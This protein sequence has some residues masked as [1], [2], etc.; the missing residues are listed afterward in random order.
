MRILEYGIRR[1][2]QAYVITVAY[3]KTF[4]PCAKMVELRI[5]IV[6]PRLT[7]ILL[8]LSLV[9][10]VQL[11]KPAD[12]HPLSRILLRSHID[13]LLLFSPLLIQTR[14]TTVNMGYHDVAGHERRKPTQKNEMQA[15]RQ[16]NVLAAASHVRRLFESKKLTYAVMGELALLCLGHRCEVRDIFIA[17]DD[18]DCSRIK[19][20]LEGDRRYVISISLRDDRLT[21]TAYNCQRA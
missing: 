10:L 15:P 18:K 20:K 16:S 7:R 19:K 6:D 8:N 5:D 13:V 11:R 4:H 17:Y 1:A 3:R 2:V 14:N 21:A 12:G 9:H